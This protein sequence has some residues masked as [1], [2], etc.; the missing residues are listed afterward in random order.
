[1]VLLSHLFGM[2]EAEAMAALS[3]L[4]TIL[5]GRSPVQVVHG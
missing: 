1:M 5:S 3:S 2:E 4:D